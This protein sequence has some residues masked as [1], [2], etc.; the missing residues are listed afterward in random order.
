MRYAVATRRA[1][2]DPIV[3]LKGALTPVKR[4]HYATIVSPPLVGELLRNIEG[5]RGKLRVVHCALRLLPLVFVR[6]PGRQSWFSKSCCRSP[7]PTA[8]CSQ[9]FAVRLAP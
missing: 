1:E 9:A 7:V 2:R 8:I 4:K 5:Y 6:C 3:D